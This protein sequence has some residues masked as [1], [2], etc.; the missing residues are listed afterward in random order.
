MLSILLVSTVAV[1]PEWTLL[2]FPRATRALDAGPIEPVL[3]DAAHLDV[4]G[5]FR[6]AAVEM[7]EAPLPPAI[8]QQMLDET[9]RQRGQKLETRPQAG[10]LLARGEPAALEAAR[11]LVADLDRQTAAFEIDLEVTLRTAG[12]PESRWRRRALAGS[13]VFLGSRGSRPFVAGFDVQVAQDAGQAEPRLGAALFGTGLH[14]RVT[15]LAGGARV[16]VDGVFDSA[17]IA[18]VESFDPE[19]PDLGVFEQPRV[20]SVQLAFSGSVESGGALEVRLAEAGPLKGETVLTVRATARPDAPA[21][22][23]GWTLID[24]GFASLAPRPLLDVEPGLALVGR[25]YEADAGGALLTP[26]ALAALLESDRAADGRSG[27]ALIL[28]G[29]TLL[30]IPRTDAARI[31]AARALLRAAED[32]R[33][34]TQRVALECGPLR[35]SFPVASGRT[36]RLVAGTERPYLTDYGLEVAPQVWMPSPR[37]ERSFDGISADIAW[38]GGV[39]TLDAWRASTP[40]VT[41]ASREAAQMGRLQL[42]LRARTAGSARTVIGEPP[43]AVFDAG[44]VLV[45]TLGA[46]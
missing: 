25:G 38:S 45:L 20:E 32:A 23:D 41:V 3:L 19:T 1:A 37:V 27:R 43:I 15:R 14:L 11:A 10:L 24:L 22:G 9:L 44:P 30:A 26:A 29:R 17:A 42:P 28:W 34:T 40:E 2:A 7:P 5:S 8:F 39:A 33:A 16:H 35:A 12:A 46:P 4:D 36:A 31:E 18:A 6:P 13:E 21:T